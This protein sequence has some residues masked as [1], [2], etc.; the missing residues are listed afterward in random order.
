MIA[1]KI[2]FFY[3]LFSLTFFKSLY[4]SIN[5][6][7]LI[8]VEDK[9]VTNYELKNKILTTLFLAGEEINQENINRLKRA[10]ADS[11]ITNKLKLIELDKTNISINKTKLNSYLNS[12]S[13]NKFKIMPKK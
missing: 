2:I 6:K 4:A 12:I 1:K 3:I 13:S 10:A 7:I 11:L 9:I 8:K 5:N